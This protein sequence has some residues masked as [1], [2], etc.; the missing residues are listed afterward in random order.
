MYKRIIE[1]TNYHTFFLFGMRG[2]GKSTLLQE[3]YKNINVMWINLLLA[4]HYLKYKNNPD[5]LKNE[6][7]GLKKTGDLPDLVVI[8]EVQKNPA[9]LDIVHYLIEKE[10][11][12]FALTGS[13]ALFFVY[14]HLHFLNW[15]MILI[16]ILIFHGVGYL[17]FL[18]KIW[19]TIKIKHDF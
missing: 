12:I 3:R 5:L 16:L 13:S 9:L 7:L 17:L 19:K 8:D 2:T 11:I 14:T 4:E 6:I 18:V 1:L 10:N 15:V